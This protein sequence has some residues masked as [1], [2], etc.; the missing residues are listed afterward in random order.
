[1]QFGQKKK[2]IF[3]QFWRFF[4]SYSKCLILF[5]LSSR[6]IDSKIQRKR[7][8][9]FLSC[10]DLPTHF[11][12][13]MRMLPDGIAIFLNKKSKFVQFLDGLCYGRCWYILWPFSQFPHHLVY[14]VATWYIL[15][16]FGIFCGHVLLYVFC[17][18]VFPPFWYVLPGKIWQPC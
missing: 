9:V 1:M 3:Q 5:C 6:G 17:G 14:F 2:L 7:R 10:Q 13:K 18:H 16:R 4:R 12:L 15:W 8:P 11:Q